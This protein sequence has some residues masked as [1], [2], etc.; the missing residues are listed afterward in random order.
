MLQSN[1]YE[2]HG[3]ENKEMPVIFWKGGHGTI[4]HW[5][6]NIE[7]LYCTAGKGQLICGGAEFIMEPGHIYAVNSN[8]LHSAFD[9]GQLQYFVL[10]VDTNFLSQNFLRMQGLELETDVCSG[11]VIA[12]Y[13]SVIREMESPGPF[14]V[15]MVRS[16]CLQLV[17][18]LLRHHSRSAPGK[19]GRLQGPD[20]TIKR[21]VGYIKANFAKKLTLEEIAEEVGFSRYYFAR[22]FKKATGMTVV[23]YINLIRCRRAKKLLEQKQCSVLEAANQCGFENASYFSKTFREIMGMLPSQVTDGA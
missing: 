15:A 6:D 9:L 21:A 4:A 11:G 20:E 22:Q 8:E 14:H 2:I 3:L 17:A 5:H 18:Q 7:L 23:A 1:K 13:E 12:I 10:I 16:L 19:E